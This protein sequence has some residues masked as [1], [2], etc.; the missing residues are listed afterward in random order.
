MNDA[1]IKHNLKHG[2][3][4][5]VKQSSMMKCPHFIM[6]PEHYM[7]DG[8]CRCTDADH[9]EMKEW[10]YTWDGKSWE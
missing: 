4:L 2:K 5:L 6:T 9:V 1:E 10:G 3:V 8:S 7:A